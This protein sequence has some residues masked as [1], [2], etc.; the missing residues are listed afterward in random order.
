MIRHHVAQRAGML[1][2]ISPHFH[3]EFLRHCHLHVIHVAAIPNRLEN[4]VRETER[5]NILNCFFSKIM[6]DSINLVFAQHQ[7]YFVVQCD[8]RIKIVPK[9]F[10]DHHA[11]PFAVFFV[12]QLGRAKLFHY[13]GKK[14]G[15]VAR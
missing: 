14:V 9:R 7:A 4:A 10:F 13:D 5:Q 6:I 1:V 8:R 15:L 2:I 12:G 3:A 11:F